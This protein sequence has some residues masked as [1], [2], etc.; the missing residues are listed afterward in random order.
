MDGD[1]RR[2]VERIH[3]SPTMAVTAIAGAG[4]QALTWVL[5]V[6]GASRTVLEALVPYA[7]SSVV[8][9][10]GHEPDQFVSE[11]T[12]LDIAHSAYRRGL[13]LRENNA[14]V[15]GVGCTATIAT[16]R[17]KRGEHRAHV[18]FWTHDRATSY[19]L[20]FVKG[21]RDRD[22]EDEVVSKLVLRA[23]AEANYVDFDLPL[24]LHETERVETTSVTHEDP[25]KALLAGHVSTATVLPDSTMV[26]D[27]PVRGGL[28]PGSFNPLHW[29]HEKLA[30]AA[31]DI[32]GMDVA[33]EMSIT[34]V[35]KPPLE[36]Q[37]VRKRVAQFAGKGPVVVTSALV[38]FQK[39]ALFPRCIFVIGWD[40]AVRLVDPRYYDDEH[41][42]M[43]TALQDIRRSGCRFLVAG[44]FDGKAFRMLEDIPVPAG[45]ED[46]FTPIPEDVFRSDI[47]STEQRLSDKRPHDHK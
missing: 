1:T 20:K 41:S 45:F 14:P 26:A 19:E 32:L 43:L 34:N 12:A 33:F 24:N 37:E 27:E 22:G 29:G 6:P 4:A 23:L 25:I 40:T 30:V 44:R 21:L 10:L 39:A 13:H 16:D 36:E 46:I 7:S 2:L 28:L 5:G 8:E 31:S 42:R 47:S 9:F 35:D 11:Q 15:A 3:S 18:A 17:P 38:F